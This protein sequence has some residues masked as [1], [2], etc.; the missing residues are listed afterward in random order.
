MKPCTP[1]ITFERLLDSE[2][3]GFFFLKFAL[4]EHTTTV[5]L[6]A[7]V[8]KAHHIYDEALAADK[9]PAFSPSFVFLCKNAHVWMRIQK[10]ETAL[11]DTLVVGEF[12]LEIFTD[13]VSGAKALRLPT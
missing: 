12:E 6:N 13:T 4:Q 3:K 1:C 2:A 11:E 9:I 10:E 5:S 8:Q 7:I